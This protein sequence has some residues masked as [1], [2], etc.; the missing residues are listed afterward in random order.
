MRFDF[1]IGTQL[2]DQLRG[3]ADPDVGG[4]ERLFEGVEQR[5]VDGAAAEEAGDL[6]PQRGAG[7]LETLLQRACVRFR[8]GDI[9]DDRVLRLVVVVVGVVFVVGVGVGVA[10]LGCTRQHRGLF[11]VRARFHRVTHVFFG[12][13]A[14]AAT[15]RG[16]Q[17]E[18]E[19]HR[20]H[21]ADGYDDEA[22]G[23]IRLHARS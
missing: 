1:P 23:I 18:N 5:G 12:E 15:A 11:G 6:A 3:E 8:T 2:V 4:D 10:A 21:D 22:R 9:L 14:T 20:H 7:E 13:L 16:D 19:H 17:R